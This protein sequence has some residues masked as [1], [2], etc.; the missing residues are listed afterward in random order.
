MDLLKDLQAIIKQLEASVSLNQV[1]KM[2]GMNYITLR[3]IKFGKSKNVT[4]AVAERLRAFASTF[5]P[6]AADAP[7]PRP[8]RKPAAVPSAKKSMKKDA[9]PKAGAVKKTTK[10]TVALPAAEAPASD[11]LLVPDAPA[12]VAPKKRGR[13]KKA[14]AAVAAAP[15]APAKKRGRPKKAAVA[16]AIDA[17]AAA[18]AKK[19][20]RPKKDA[21]VK[22]V[23]AKAAPKKAAPKKRGR[24]PGSGVKSAA[25]PAATEFTSLV[26]MTD[27]KRQIELAEARLAY[28]R[29]LEKVE[30]EFIAKMG[31]K[32]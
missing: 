15:A 23:V 1:A 18:P 31:G 3:N 2:S 6:P 28:L 22:P 25:A 13:P 14:A 29:S 8:G 11:A 12:P 19:R 26:M 27:L 32:K 16:V 5:T 4:E 7:K 10:K 17:A 30:A 21:G 24:K 20:G 9:A